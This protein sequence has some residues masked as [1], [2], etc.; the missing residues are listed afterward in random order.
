MYFRHCSFARSIPLDS[1]WRYG[2][3]DVPEQTTVSVNATRNV[4]M[5]WDGVVTRRP[6][7]MQR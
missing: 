2:T 6:Q 1:P 4:V 7:E 3:S 5:N